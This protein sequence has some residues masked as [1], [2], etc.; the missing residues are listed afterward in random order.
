MAFMTR[1]V[2]LVHTTENTALDPCSRPLAFPGV[3]YSPSNK[4]PLDSGRGKIFLDR[5]EHTG[6]KL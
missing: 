6:V 4:A 2:Y 1:G 5:E 3:F